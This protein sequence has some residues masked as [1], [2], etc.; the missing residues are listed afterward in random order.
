MQK[1]V[2]KNYKSW[3]INIISLKEEKSYIITNEKIKLTKL[4]NKN[5]DKDILELNKFMLR[6]EIIHKFTKK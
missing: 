6:K 5:F 4:F 1:K 2:F 3:M